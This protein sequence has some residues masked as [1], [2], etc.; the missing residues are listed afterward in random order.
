MDVP[1]DPDVSETLVGLRDAI[2]PPGETEVERPTVPVNPFRLF[3]VIVEVPMEPA[4]M[5]RD[6]G[7]GA[8]EYSGVCTTKLP[9]IDE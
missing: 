1:E 9:T 5:E 6:D 4:W 8:S 7:V 2:G 3:S